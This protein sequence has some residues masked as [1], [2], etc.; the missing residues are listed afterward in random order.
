MKELIPDISEHDLN[1]DVD[2]NFAIWFENYVS[3]KVLLFSFSFVK[4]IM[5]FIPC[6]IGT[7]TQNK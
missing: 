5:L 2:K 7:S 1:T 3:D 4:L 6:N